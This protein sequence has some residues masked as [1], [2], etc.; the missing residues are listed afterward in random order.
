VNKLKNIL[1]EIC[2]FFPKAGGIL[3]YRTEESF[4]V[5]NN[6]IHFVIILKLLAPPPKKT[7]GL[8]ILRDAFFL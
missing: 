2:T 7:R 1:T 5:L 8:S 6:L 4:D 3:G